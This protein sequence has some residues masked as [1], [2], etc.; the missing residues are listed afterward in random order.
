MEYLKSILGST[1]LTGASV[2]F[3]VTLIIALLYFF[4]M[5]LIK[6][7]PVEKTVKGITCFLVVIWITAEIFTLLHLRILSAMLR[8]LLLL[9]MLSFVVIFQPE[10]RRWMARIGNSLS[11]ISQTKKKQMNNRLVEILTQ[12]IEYW[13][14]HQT[15]ALIVFENHEPVSAATTDGVILNADLSTELLINLFFVNT[16]LHDG[17]VVIKKDK[18]VSAGVI[19]PLTRDARLNW[20]YG[21]RHRAA[22]G[23]SENTDALV[24]VVSEENG[25]V[26]L[27]RDGQIQT[28][29]TLKDLPDKLSAFLSPLIQKSK[30]ESIW[31]R[32]KDLFVKQ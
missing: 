27:V 22:I 2:L 24:L 7:S 31:K 15:G 20:K 5:K 28:F 11:M 26:S 4:Y 29:H 12:S 16:P 8:N 23:M 30:P 13:Q 25:D 6:N 10:L 3:Q 14:E 19:L 18:V 21:T 1:G 17:A 9:I 32:M